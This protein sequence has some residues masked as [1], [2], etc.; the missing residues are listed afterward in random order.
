M[1]NYTIKDFVTN[2]KEIGNQARENECFQS[3]YQTYKGSEYEV[4]VVS[5]YS[6]SL[7][8]SKKLIETTT[9]VFNDKAALLCRATR[10]LGYGRVITDR[11]KK[12]IVIEPGKDILDL[13]ASIENVTSSDLKRTI[14]LST[15]GKSIRK[16]DLAK[17]AR[18]KRKLAD[19]KEETANKNSKNEKKIERIEREYREDIETIE[20]Q[21]TQERLKA[22][23]D[24]E[25]KL[26]SEME[27]IENKYKERINELEQNNSRMM[28]NLINANQENKKLG[29]TPPTSP[30]P[31]MLGKSQ[32]PVNPKPLPGSACTK[33]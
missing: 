26:N 28:N 20:F 6:D 21:A 1:S 16:L 5:W 19:T 13:W 27:S 8:K 12:T 7:D 25:E 22:E 33:P 9:R 23:L 18:E 29:G 11:R 2:W 30:I 15:T 24:A 17:L 32:G 14:R 31:C 10:D 4:L 3:I